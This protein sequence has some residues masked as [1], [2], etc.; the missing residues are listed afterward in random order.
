MGI[1]LTQSIQNG[2]ATAVSDGSFKDFYGTSCSVLRGSTNHRII[3][4]N[5]VPGPRDIQSSYRSEL[6]GISGNLLI[7]QAIC[8]KYSVSSHSITMALDN[9]SAIDTITQTYPLNPKQA[10]HDLLWDIR[11]KLSRLPLHIN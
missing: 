4:I 3:S 2:T 9:Q 10:D 6:A 11:T 1:D 5:L 7:L 8:N